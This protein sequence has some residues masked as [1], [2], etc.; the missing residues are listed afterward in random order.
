[1]S[2]GSASHLLLPRTK[3]FK[4]EIRGTPSQER[5]MRNCVDMFYSQATV[6]GAAVQRGIRRR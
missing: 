3:I 1:M 2:W 4:S 5:F 6:Y